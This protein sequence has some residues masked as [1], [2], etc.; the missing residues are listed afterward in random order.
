MVSADSTLAESAWRGLGRD[1]SALFA[2]YLPESAVDKALALGNIAVTLPYVK[3][4]S[5]ELLQTSYSTSKEAADKLPATL[6]S[7]YQ[8]H[9]PELYA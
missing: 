3:K 2:V 6:V 4:K 8:Q 9:Y 7:F 5:V 1:C